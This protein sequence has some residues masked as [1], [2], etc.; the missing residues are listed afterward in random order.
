LSYY[1]IRDIYVSWLQSYLTN[2]NQKVNLWSSN[3]TE[4]FSSSCETIKCGVPQGSVLAP[5]L[6]LIY[7]NDLPYWFNNCAKFVLS[8]DDKSVLV[9]ANDNT[10]LQLKLHSTLNNISNWFT[11]DGLSL[12]IEKTNIIKFSTH[13]S[14][15]EAI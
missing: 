2:R 11:T 13:H 7:I 5:L 4:E 14:Q 9:A 15:E 1:G 3:H 6:F 12:N 8:A 10:E